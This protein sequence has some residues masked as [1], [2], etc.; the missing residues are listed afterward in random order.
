MIIRYLKLLVSKILNFKN[1]TQFS[2]KNH[3]SYANTCIN[4]ISYQK[5]QMLLFPLCKSDHHDHCSPKE[6]NLTHLLIHFVEFS[7][8]VVGKVCTADQFFPG[9]LGHPKK[10]DTNDRPNQEWIDPK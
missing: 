8:F 7:Y 4:T 1:K 10:Y 5:I 3:L 2:L 6:N 9:W